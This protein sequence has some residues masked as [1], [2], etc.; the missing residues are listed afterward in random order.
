[1]NTLDRIREKINNAGSLDFSVII[2]DTIELFK[3]VWLNGF[4]IVLIIMAFSFSLSM[5]ISFIGLGPDPFLYNDWFNLELAMDYMSV[6]ALYS[7]PQNI[8]VSSLTI[9]LL[10]GFYRICREVDSGGQ[11]KDDYFYFFKQEYLGKIFALGVI[12]AVISSMAIMLFFV[13][14]IYV[15]VPLAFF[16]VVFA[17]NPDLS[18]VEIVK[19]SFYLGNKK[20]LVSFGTM[21]VAAILGALGLLACG[22][23]LLFTISIAYLPAYLIYRDVIG[24]DHGGTDSLGERP[25]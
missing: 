17:N 12:H 7:I 3:K 2:S 15:F 19:A 25:W 10:G 4:L 21:L 9:A 6:N 1:M 8:I 18:E 20:W 13:P 5:L 23:G 11:V 16:S 22:I 24:F 14:Y